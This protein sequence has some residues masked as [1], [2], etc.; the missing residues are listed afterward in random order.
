[1]TTV[2]DDVFELFTFN[3]ILVGSDGDAFSF[4]EYDKTIISTSID[5]DRYK[6]NRC[7]ACDRNCKQTKYNLGFV[8]YVVFLKY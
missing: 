6:R 5:D 8:D 1:M 3:N 7:E 2:F 4:V